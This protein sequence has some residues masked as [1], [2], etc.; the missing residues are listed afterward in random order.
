M[1]FAGHHDLLF[2]LGDS[3]NG[4]A[5]QNLGVRHASAGVRIAILASLCC[6]VCNYRIGGLVAQPA[7]VELGDQPARRPVPELERARDEALRDV[8][9]DEAELGEDL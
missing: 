6:S 1:P 3:G 4:T 2:V 9:V 8:L 5:E 7:E